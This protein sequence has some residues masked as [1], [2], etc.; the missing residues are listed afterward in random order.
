MKLLTVATLTA[1]AIAGLSEQ[2]KAALSP[3]SITSNAITSNS[4]THNALVSNA[5]TSNSLIGNALTSNSLSFN[6][7][8]SQMATI[9]EQSTRKVNPQA[10]QPETLTLSNAEYAT[11]KVEGGR[12]VGVK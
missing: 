6:A 1:F 5:L 12:L 11:I 7:L 9:P 4:L 2:V 8:S 10:F 3:N